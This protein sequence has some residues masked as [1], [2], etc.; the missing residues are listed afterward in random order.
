MFVG[1]DVSKSW[2]DVGVLSTGR[3]RRFDNDASGIEELMKLVNALEN[4]LVVLEATGGLQM[5]VASELIAAGIRVAIVN[6]RQVRQ[7]A[8]A[9]GLLA[10]TD[11]I[12]AILLARFGE[13]MKPDCRPLPSTE[14]QLLHALV[15]R[16][17]QLTTMLVSEKNRLGSSPLAIQDNIAKHI[18]WLKEQIDDI[19]KQAGKHIENSPSWRVKDELLRTVPGIGPVVARSLLAEL[20]ELGTLNQ[21]QI[22]SLVG[23]APFNRDSGTL[24]G[25]RCIWGGRAQVRRVLYMAALVASRHNQTCRIFYQRLLAAGKPRKL[26]LIA[27]M[28]KMLVWI[29]AMMR[30]EKPWEPQMAA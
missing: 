4:P 17:R 20:P 27:L 18:A 6:P 19:D 29:N 22:A 28:R 10:K 23:V 25:K 13:A 12:D 3:V 21:K 16:R 5:P 30:D 9:L 2:L 8:K 7:F 11:A 15:A 14:T 24:K 26:A 1:I